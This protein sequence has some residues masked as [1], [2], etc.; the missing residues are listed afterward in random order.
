MND[1]HLAPDEERD[2]WIND[3]DSGMPAESEVSDQKSE[4]R[5]DPT[6]EEPKPCFPTR[7][8]ANGDLRKPPV[9]EPTNEK[10]HVDGCKC[11]WCTELDDKDGDSPTNEPYNEISRSESAAQFFDD[12]ERYWEEHPNTINEVRKR[13]KEREQSHD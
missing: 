4:V 12:L 8:D 9:E 11:C 3:A 7:Y 10:L 5:T 2:A 1:Y 6:N 13:I